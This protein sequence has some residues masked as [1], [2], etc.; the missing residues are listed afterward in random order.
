MGVY[1][2]VVSNGFFGNCKRQP[3]RHNHSSQ[4]VIGEVFVKKSML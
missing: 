1:L 4:F 2:P 3:G